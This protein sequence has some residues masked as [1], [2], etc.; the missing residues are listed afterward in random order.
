MLGEVRS[1]PQCP[2]LYERKEEKE[3][4]EGEFAFAFFS[5]VWIAV[6]EAR[7]RPGR[8]LACLFFEEST[9]LYPL[10]LRFLFNSP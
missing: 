4:P 3:S 2:G 10:P 7:L 6:W 5:E 1:L 8:F 9:F